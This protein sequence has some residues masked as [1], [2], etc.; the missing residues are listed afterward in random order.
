[1]TTQEKL[2]LAE[3]SLNNPSEAMGLKQYIELLLNVYPT[4]LYERRLENTAT[5]SDLENGLADETDV[6]PEEDDLNEDPEEESEE[7]EEELKED[8]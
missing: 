8:E 1:M 5:G 6:E 7:V 4:L 3:Q 2:N